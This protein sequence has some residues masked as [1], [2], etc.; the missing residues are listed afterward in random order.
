VSSKFLD[1]VIILANCH[2][3]KI[4]HGEVGEIY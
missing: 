1:K 4:L 2:A 3:L